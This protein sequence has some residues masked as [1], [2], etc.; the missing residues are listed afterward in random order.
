MIICDN[1]KE[2]DLVTLVEGSWTKDFTE[3]EKKYYRCGIVTEIIIRKAPAIKRLNKPTEEDDG[4]AKYAEVRWHSVY[5]F[6][7]N[8]TKLPKHKRARDKFILAISLKKLNKSKG[9]E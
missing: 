5:W 4:R 2:G 1:I 7:G 6:T 8:K 9:E 3:E